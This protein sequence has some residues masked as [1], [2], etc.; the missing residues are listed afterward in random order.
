MRECLAFPLVKHILGGLSLRNLILQ[1]QMRL[2][3]MLWYSHLYHELVVVAWG[4]FLQLPV[5]S[6]LGVACSFNNPHSILQHHHSHCCSPEDGLH[7][8]SPR[9]WCSSEK[10]SGISPMSFVHL[11]PVNS[12]LVAP[13]NGGAKT[14]HQFPKILQL[15]KA[16][17]PALCK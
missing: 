10:F 1:R 2:K 5:N 3:K 14:N 15:G 13:K 4:F 6:S 7:S 16:K 11:S 8:L 12:F 9:F 17:E